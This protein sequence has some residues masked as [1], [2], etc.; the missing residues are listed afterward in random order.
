MSENLDALGRPQSLFQTVNDEPSRTIQ[1][2]S[3][4][5]SIH[6][7]LA[8]HGV[9]G[10]IEHLNEADLQFG[11][12]SNIVDYA[13]ASRI[14][15][16]AEAQFLRLPPKVRGVF[17]NDVALWLDAA[18]DGLQDEQRS[19]L[20]KLGFLEEIVSPEPPAAPIAP[21]PVTDPPPTE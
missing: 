19:Q 5:A 12:A 17:E 2:D 14:M 16:E 13:E 1:S 20:V 8:R 11:D 7:I 21:D 4:E 9:T 3:N 15:V 6:T 18:N 10:V